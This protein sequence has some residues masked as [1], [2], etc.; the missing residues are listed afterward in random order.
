M[1]AS[2]NTGKAR[3]H[4]AEIAEAQHPKYA[5]FFKQDVPDVEVGQEVLV[6]YERKREFMQQAARIESTTQTEDDEQLRFEFELTGEVISAES[7]QCFR[8][9]T[10][11]SD[12]TADL[13]DEADCQL[14][15]VSV[16]GFA[17]TASTVHKI[18]QVV[19]AKLR[20]Q[21]QE[22]SGAV[23]IQSIRELGPGQIRYGLHGLST[24]EGGGN[25]LRGIA[26]IS[27]AVQRQ[28]LQR[29]AGV[30]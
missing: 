3:L 19:K 8:V 28:Q 27:T 20:H 30:S 7:R 23:R 21:D 24:L 25:L 11:I 29:L 12:M 4:A 2:D 16:T 10:V 17:V 18:G 26:L 6:Y 15:D 14:M 5:A 13:G 22:F 1:K 9:S